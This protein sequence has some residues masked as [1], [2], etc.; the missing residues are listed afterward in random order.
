MENKINK[1]QKILGIKFKEKKCGFIEKWPT[2]KNLYAWHVILKQQGYQKQHS[3]PLGWLSG[4]IYLKTVPSLKNNEGSIEFNLNGDIYSDNNSAKKIHEPKIGDIVLF[5]SSLFHKTIPF[6]TNT[7]RIIV[8][9]DLKP[10]KKDQVS[11][12]EYM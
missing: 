5:P 9:F 11:K 6:S 10:D 1:L 7:D 4:V 12:E 8:S 2:E 3:H